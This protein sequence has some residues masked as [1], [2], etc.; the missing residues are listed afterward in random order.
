MIVGSVRS[1]RHQLEQR[2]GFA[3]LG[4][5]PEICFAGCEGDMK[6]EFAWY[7]GVSLWISIALPSAMLKM[8]GDPFFAFLWLEASLFGFLVRC[9]QNFFRRYLPPPKLDFRVVRR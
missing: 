4:R 5:V 2:L 1:L 3:R 7:I 6:G 8:T 9:R